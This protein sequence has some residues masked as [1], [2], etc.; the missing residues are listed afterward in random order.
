M[1]IRLYLDTCI[2]NDAFLISRAYS[3]EPVGRRDHKQ[4]LGAWILEYVALYLPFRL[5]RMGL[6]RI[7][8]ELCI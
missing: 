4:P 2:A 8:R 5:K 1:T 6:T 3:R 7:Y